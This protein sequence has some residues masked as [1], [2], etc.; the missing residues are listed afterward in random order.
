[1]LGIRMNKILLKIELGDWDGGHNGQYPR[2]IE[3]N[4]E[5]ENRPVE[6]SEGWGHGFG[7]GNSSL[8]IFAQS[9]QFYYLSQGDSSWAH[10]IILNALQ[11]GLTVSE[12]GSLLMVEAEKHKVNLP[13]HLQ[14][15]LSRYGR[16]TNA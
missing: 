16:Y 11:K 12:V 13:L 10:Q 4:L 9:K 5:D 2:V 14:A 8:E 3:W 1:M 7:G 15:V 6:E